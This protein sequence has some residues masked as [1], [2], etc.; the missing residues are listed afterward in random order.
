MPWRDVGHRA[1]RGSIYTAF[2]LA[3]PE[4]RF[5]NGRVIENTTLLRQPGALRTLGVLAAL[6]EWVRCAETCPQQCVSLQRAQVQR[7]W[8]VGDHRPA[9]S[10]WAADTDLAGA[11]NR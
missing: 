8:L 6:S 4:R 2:Y 1:H 9:Q 7:C 5:V 11:P 3:G 10:M